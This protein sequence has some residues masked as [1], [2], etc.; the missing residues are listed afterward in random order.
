MEV[1]QWNISRWLALLFSDW[2]NNEQQSLL[3]G[4]TTISNSLVIFIRYLLLGG[5]NIQQYFDN[6]LEFD[7]VTETWSEAG[8]MKAARGKPGVSVVNLDDVLDYATDCVDV[9]N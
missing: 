2:H 9:K 3:F 5:W 1:D 6:I 7:T 8:K 4:Y